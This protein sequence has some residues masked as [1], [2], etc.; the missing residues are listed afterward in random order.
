MA[1][2]GDDLNAHLVPMARFLPEPV[3]RILRQHF[4]A[5][6]KQAE[7]R[8]KFNAGDEDAITG[9]LGQ[10]LIEPKPLFIQ[11]NDHVFQWRTV[12]YKLRGRGANAPETKYG[13]DGIF[14]LE[15]ADRSGQ[16]LLRKGLL[17][18]SKIRW[19]GRNKRLL[20]QARDLLQYSQ[21]AIVI[22]YSDKGYRAIAASDI[23]TAEGDRK[24]L[25]PENDKSLAAVLGDEF[26]QCRCG[27]RG[28]YWDQET[29]RLIV[30][31]ERESDLIPNELINTTIQQ[32]Q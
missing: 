9:A 31:G 24:R 16:F 17:F 12:S 23:L 3:I 29:E 6:V 8:F 26:V 7:I 1:T 20:N 25:D 19:R 18:Q 30:G 13:A 32:V 14:Q 10:A 28:L 2:N 11:I 22:D 21:T 15:I 5:G 4:Y 27:D